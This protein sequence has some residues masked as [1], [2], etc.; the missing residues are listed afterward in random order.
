M[1]TARESLKSGA[2]P[3]FTRPIGGQSITGIASS[4]IWTTSRFF[5]G[6]NA[7]VPSLCRAAKLAFAAATV[8]APR[9][10]L[11][12]GLEVFPGF[13]GLVHRQQD[14]PRAP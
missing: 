7:I 12:S 1:Q 5:F 13:F 2:E 8:L 3:G 14:H 11:A 9:V 10:R 4:A 6:D